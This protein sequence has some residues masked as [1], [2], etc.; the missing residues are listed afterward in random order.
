MNILS[1]IIWG[2]ALGTKL[3]FIIIGLVAV[4]VTSNTHPIW[5]NNEDPEAP[6][7]FKPEWPGWFRQYWWRAIRNP[8]NNLRYLIDEP[9]EYD[10]AWGMVNPDEAVRDQGNERAYRFVRAGLYSEYWYL[11]RVGDEYFEFR[12]GWKFS[13]VPGFAPTFQL[14]KG[15]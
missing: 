8:A 2:P 9:T 14:R 10:F 12:I 5:G 15:D 1:V 4:P 7:W 13:G 3:L 6:K 11:K